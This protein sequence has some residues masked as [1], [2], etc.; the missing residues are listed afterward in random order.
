VFQSKRTGKAYSDVA[1]LA[2]MKTAAERF[3]R[4]IL[5]SDIAGKLAVPHGFRSS[6]RVWATENKADDRSAEMQ[7][8]HVVGDEVRQAYDRAVLLEQRREL[9][10]RWEQYV[11][12]ATGGEE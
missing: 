3:G 7:L 6:F 8:G 1:L 10:T 4:E 12:S 11:F 5:V 9:M 2:V